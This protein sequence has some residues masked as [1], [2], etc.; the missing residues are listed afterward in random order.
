MEQAKPTGKSAVFTAVDNA[1][2]TAIKVRKDFSFDASKPV[3]R[4]IADN[5]DV[6]F[7]STMRLDTPEKYT[8]L[9]GDYEKKLQSLIPEIKD[10]VVSMA[11]VQGVEQREL[12]RGYAEKI[13]MAEADVLTDKGLREVLK[14]QAHNILLEQEGLKFSLAYKNF[15]SGVIPEDDFLKS[16]QSMMTAQTQRASLLTGAGR[17]LRT[18]QNSTMATNLNAL[19][20]E[21]GQKIDD[22]TALFVGPQTMDK[23]KMKAFGES[24]AQAQGLKQILDLSEDEFT[25]AVMKSAIGAD[26]IAKVGA[27]LPVAITAAKDLL[28]T[29]GRTTQAALLTGP[30]TI[31]QNTLGTAAMQSMTIG[32]GYIKAGLKGFGTTEMMKANAKLLGTIDGY[33]QAFKAM[34]RATRSAGARNS[35]GTLPFTSRLKMAA[36]DIPAFNKTQAQQY[37]HAT[38]QEIYNPDATGNMIYDGMQKHFLGRFASSRWALDIIQIQDTVSKTAT[39]YAGMRERMVAALHVDDVFDLKNYPED[40]AKAK[41]LLSKMMANGSDEV[42]VAEVRKMFGDERALSIVSRMNEWREKATTEAFEEATDVVF[43]RELKGT[44]EGVRSFMQDTIPGGKV[45]VP[46]FTTPVNILS[47]S[48]KRIPM[49]PMGDGGMGMPIHPQIYKDFFN[50]AKRSD[51]VSKVIMGNILAYAGAQLTD[52]GFY[53]PVPASVDAKSFL[54]QTMGQTPGSMLLNGKSYSTNFLGPIHNILAAGG[55]VHNHDDIYKRI[56]QLDDT[57]SQKYYDAIQYNMM[58]LASLVTEQPYVSGIDQIVELLGI[59]DVDVDDERQKKAFGDRMAQVF[60]QKAG[61]MMPSSSLARNISNNFMDYQ[62]KADSLGEHM[63]SQFAPWL[64]DNYAFDGYGNKIEPNRGWMLRYRN[65]VATDLDHKLM[66]E[67]SFIPKRSKFKYNYTMP[68]NGL[69]SNPAATVNLG[70]LGLWNEWNEIKASG[71]GAEIRSFTNTKEYSDNIKFG[72]ID[73]N[74]RA[75]QSI[76]FTKEKRAFETL[77]TKY[78]AVDGVIAR[79]VTRTVEGRQ[80]GVGHITNAPSFTGGQ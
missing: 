53:Q 54:Q 44:L 5:L 9:L 20:K 74:Q 36:G 59:L 47:E 15:K 8:A 14:A 76:I 63:L 18:S 25:E 16:V 67:I 73:L 34:G 58:N 66:D 30:V 62:M 50:P 3:D 55:A 68:S 4:V 40:M 7:D 2:D 64:L 38:K 12:L 27:K 60:G 22:V 41:G 72:R 52:A 11:K 23:A 56:D 17:T 43:Q 51:A 48:L 69:R 42:N 28:D 10:K 77:R 57:E 80:K 1:A 19:L 75:I 29:F 33:K 71:L 49:I 31:T 46:F 21:T 24:M 6:T 78:P 70:E 61:T 79:E 32:E 65:I 45:F 26:D 13:G 39:A 35:V 37:L